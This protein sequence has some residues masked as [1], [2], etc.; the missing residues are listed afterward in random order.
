M[1][2]KAVDWVLDFSQAEGGVR[3]VAIVLA[4]NAD[5]DT[6]ECFPTIETI[7]RRARVSER[8][9]R[10]A[11]R[12]L[13]TLG[14]LE[15]FQRQG[16][17]KRADRRSNLYV[18]TGYMASR[19]AKSAPRE[20]LDEGQI[21]LDEGQ[22]DAPTRGNPLPVE[23]SVEPSVLEPSSDAPPSSVAKPRPRNEVWDAIAAIFP[24]ATKGE[25]ALVGAVEKLL[26]AMDPLPEPA[27]I[28]RR[29]RWARQEWPTCTP[30][31]LETRW[32]M[33]GERVHGARRREVI[34]KYGTNP[35][36]WPHWDAEAMAEIRAAQLEAS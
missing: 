17:G 35:A 6:G 23:P 18:L 29:G 28:V 34:A 12:A 24:T 30:K 15:T 25:R 14:E 20:N 11:L 8:T 16:R 22:S 4:E 13:E 33:I 36:G 9:A 21:S 7:A 32:T 5:Q 31:V 19:G 3:L 2:F 26:R 10:S 27:E 1:S